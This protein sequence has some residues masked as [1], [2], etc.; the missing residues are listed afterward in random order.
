MFTGTLFSNGRSFWY[1]YSGCKASCLTPF[2]SLCTRFFLCCPVRTK[3][4]VFSERR[5]GD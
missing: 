1:H 2:K 4:S 5:E 3:C